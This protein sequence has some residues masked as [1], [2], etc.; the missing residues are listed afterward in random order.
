M[1]CECD[2]H[3]RTNHFKW[4]GGDTHKKQHLQNNA[5]A[6]NF[7]DESDELIHKTLAY[8][9]GTPRQQK[10]RTVNEHSKKPLTRAAFIKKRMNKKKTLITHTYTY[11]QK[12]HIPKTLLLSI[13][14]YGMQIHILSALDQSVS[15]T[16]CAQLRY[17]MQ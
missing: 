6:E 5:R 15:P 17:A 8:E 9:N 16:Q 1:L 7:H 2:T 10:K 12:A 13:D 11:T 3:K 4:G 14:S